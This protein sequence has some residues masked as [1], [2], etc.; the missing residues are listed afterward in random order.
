[1]MGNSDGSVG[2][3]RRTVLETASTAAV[4]SD[5]FSGVT[6]ATDPGQISF[7]GCSQACLER[8][9]TGGTF[10]VVLAR[11]GD[12]D[13]AWGFDEVERPMGAG[14]GVDAA[15]AVNPTRIPSGRSSR[16]ERTRAVPAAGG[17]RSTAT[18][19]RTGVHGRRSP[20]TRPL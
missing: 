16:C 4:A 20:R 18:A 11:E 13:D 15:A 12:S 5:T 2:S 3:K 10:D 17:V 1:M 8:E 6:S 7:C 19:T 9:G 14:G